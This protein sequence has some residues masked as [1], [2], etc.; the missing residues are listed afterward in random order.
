[1]QDVLKIVGSRWKSSRTS[2]SN[3]FIYGRGRI[4]FLIFLTLLNLWIYVLLI[5]MGVM[6]CIYV[7]LIING[8]YL[9]YIFYVLGLHPSALINDMHYLSKKKEK[10]D[11]IVVFYKVLVFVI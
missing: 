10:N 6:S 7:L 4:I 2:W 3:R 9:L 5:I 8:D 11:V 1:M